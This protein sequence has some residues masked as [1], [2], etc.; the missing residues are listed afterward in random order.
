[1]KLFSKILMISI[2][3]AGTSVNAQELVIGDAANLEISPSAVLVLSNG[4]NLVNN[5]TT[6]SLNGTFIFKGT[7]P[8]EISG[9][10]PVTIGYLNLEESAFV[11]LSNNV[12]ISAELNLT[13]GI[14]NLLDN[15]MRI[16]EGASINGS[17]S[18]T[19]M[20][21]A[22]GNGKL[23][24]EVSSNGSY[25]FPVGDTSDVDEYSPAELVFSAGTYTDAVLSVNLKNIKHPNNASS[26]DY[27]NRYW[28]VS[29]SGITDFNCDVSFTYTNNDIA[30]AES[31]MIGGQ[32]NGSY[33]APLNA[34]SLNEITGLVYGLSDFTGG[35]SAILNVESISKEDV[36][37]LVNGNRVILNSSSNFPIKQVEV[38]NKLGQRIQTL[39]PANA[40]HHEFSIG[41][42][43]DI[44]LLR[45][46]S[47]NKSFT[48]KIYIE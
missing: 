15:N 2:F 7:L 45:L 20:I 4:M 28:S 5:S 34:L 35:E 19:A 8:Q 29:Q 22:E 46:S 47:T 26:T 13:S 39:S 17:F 43:P 1:M 36:Q 24:L 33:W 21:A 6:G 30:G 40:L 41:E 31:N 44:Y 11:S 42:K 10:Q 48:E 23:E 27:L 37:V 25:L 18:E 3:I 9:S 32:W 12:N 14:V 38:F 16:I